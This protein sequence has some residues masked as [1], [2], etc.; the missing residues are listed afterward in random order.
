[1]VSNDGY[2]WILRDYCYNDICSANNL[3]TIISYKYI[4]PVEDFDFTAEDITVNKEKS[5][6]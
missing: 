6:I 3:E 5:I 4:V 2:L 1:M